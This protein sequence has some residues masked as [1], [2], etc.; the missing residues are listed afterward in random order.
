M[1]SG[2]SLLCQRASFLKYGTTAL[3]VRCLDAGLAIGPGPFFCSPIRALKQVSS[4]FGFMRWAR[5]PCSIASNGKV[6]WIIAC[7]ELGNPIFSGP[8]KNRLP[9]GRRTA[10]R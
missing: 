2:E 4:T 9:V 7:R 5:N 1:F 3:V 6:G 10:Q 8:C